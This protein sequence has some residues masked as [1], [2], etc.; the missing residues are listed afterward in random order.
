MLST[1]Y[2]EVYRGHTIRVE[3]DE[4]PFNPRDDS[5]M[6]T[7]VCAHRR[8]RLGDEQSNQETSK[9]LYNELVRERGAV[10]IKQLYLYDHSGL[11]INTTGFSCGWDSGVVGFIYATRQDI[12]EWLQCKNMTKKV[13]ELANEI[14]VDEVKAYDEYLTGDV[15]RWSVKDA[16]GDHLDSCGGYF[17]DANYALKDA[18]RS[19]EGMVTQEEFDFIN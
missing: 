13:L 1:P 8:Y 17:G 14:L 9:D 6:G 16:D 3:I 2:E 18:K 11:T 5:N 10:V 4:D 15:Y 7:M 19:V 12:Q